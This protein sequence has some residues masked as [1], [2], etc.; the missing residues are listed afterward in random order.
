MKAIVLASILFTTP[1][2][3]V[4]IIVGEHGDDAHNQ[5]AYRSNHGLVYTAGKQ[6]DVDIV[7]GI[8][9]FKESTHHTGHRTHKPIIGAPPE[10][11]AMMVSPFSSFATSMLPTFSIAA[12]TSFTGRPN[13]L[14]PFSI[15]RAEGVSTLR[16]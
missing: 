10:M 16:Q 2:T 7:T 13:R 5:T 14:I 3:S 1:S 15:I 8:R 11:V 12:C 4:T 9:H 6:G